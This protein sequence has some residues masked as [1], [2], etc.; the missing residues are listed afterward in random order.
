MSERPGLMLGW[1]AAAALAVVFLAGG[2]ALAIVAGR[3][4][5][6]SRPAEPQQSDRSDMRGM[7]TPAVPSSPSAPIVGPLPDVG[8]TITPATAAKAGIEVATVSTVDGAGPLRIPGIVEP[9]AY[10]QV[11]VTP[12]V[13]GRITR[14]QA[15]LG[16]R[17]SRGQSLAQIFSPDLA[18][19]QTTFLAK[20]ADVEAAHHRLQRAEKL[21]AIGAASQQEVEQFAAEHTGHA[22]ELEGLRSRLVLLGL[23]PEQVQRLNAAS[24]V[25]STVSVPAPFDGVITTRTA[26][27]GANVEPAAALFTVVDLSTVWVVGSLYERD[28]LKVRVGSAATVTTR[29][30]PSLAL[31]GRVGYIDPQVS[32]ES[33]TARVRVEV[34]NRGQ[35]LRFGMY[36]E[37]TFGAAGTTPQVTAPASAVQT[38]AGRSV[39]YVRDPRREGRFVEREVQVGQTVNETVEILAGLVAGDVVVSKGTF[40]VRAERERT[41]PRR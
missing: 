28:F 25:T 22:T 5:S 8:V 33:R 36:A 6:R 37:M 11:V 20:R 35:Q 4:G 2:A 17:V 41:A 19:A 38:V 21:L 1:P 14:V 18:A 7:V 40:F 12:L 24:D 31:S 9:N 39:V 16:V 32:P 30:Y 27:A 10:R 29:A 3:V 26:N 15:E 34:P 13:A 23:G